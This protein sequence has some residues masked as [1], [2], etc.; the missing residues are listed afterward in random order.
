MRKTEFVMLCLKIMGIYF[1]LMGLINL[2]H[3]IKNLI[4]PKYSSWDFYVSPLLFLICGI[5]LFYQAPSFTRFI[6]SA[7]KEN[8]SEIEFSPTS[9]TIRIALQVVGF[10]ILATAIPHFFQI[11]VNAAAYYYEISTIPEHLRQKQQHFIYLFGPAIKIAI[12]IW[13]VLGSKAIINILGRFDSTI[14]S[15]ETSNKANEA[16]V[17]KPSGLP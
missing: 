9:N 13:L 1:L 15:M 6:I 8:G 12:G 3:L 4:E 7:E 14:S 5:T 16:D 10:Y 17:K 11:L 2:P